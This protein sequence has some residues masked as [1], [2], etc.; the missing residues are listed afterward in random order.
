MTIALFARTLASD[1]IFTILALW[2]PDALAFTSVWRLPWAK[3]LGLTAL[4]ILNV[5]LNN[6]FISDLV[7][8]PSLLF[9]DVPADRYRP[10]WGDIRSLQS[11]GTAW[12][13][14]W[15]QGLR[16]IAS[17]PAYLLLGKLQLP[18]GTFLY[19]A[20]HVVTA[21]TITGLGHMWTV[22]AAGNSGWRTL[23]FFELQA[24]GVIFE[25]AL[26]VLSPWSCP[27]WIKRVWAVGFVAATAPLYLEDW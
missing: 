7:C 14:T 25:A 18:R 4:S 3:Q 11:L 13:V 24:A 20:L 5:S 2:L 21:F 10:Y 19:F 6:P 27:L 23:A 26:Y 22:L 12:G 9:S 1:V 8:L 17:R 16:R 15:H